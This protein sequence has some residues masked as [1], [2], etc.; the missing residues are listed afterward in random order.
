MKS[1]I[2]W[3]CV[4]ALLLF[5]GYGLLPVMIPDNKQDYDTPN[6]LL[7][8]DQ[9]C[10]CPSPN[11]RLLKGT[12]VA[13][14]SIRSKYPGLLLDVGEVELENFPPYKRPIVNG[15]F[16]LFNQFK[17]KGYISGVDTLSCDPEGCI[18]IPRFTVQS[19]SMTTY[20]SKFWLFP[21]WLAMLY[22]IC[23]LLVLPGLIIYTLYQVWER[24]IYP[25]LWPGNKS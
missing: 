15:D 20:Y 13:S 3:I 4:I 22:A 9:E 11:S 12:L 16:I 14:D 2:F 19:W 17:V 5:V 25:Y 1:R 23:L 18:L 8:K 21:R 24:Y 10:G 6:T 7:I